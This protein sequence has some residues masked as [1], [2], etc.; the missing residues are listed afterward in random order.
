MCGKN[1]GDVRIATRIPRPGNQSPILFYAIPAKREY[2]PM[3]GLYCKTVSYIGCGTDGANKLT[4]DTSLEL[5]Y[6]PDDGRYTGGGSVYLEMVIVVSTLGCA[7]TEILLTLYP[8]QEGPRGSQEGGHK[9]S[10]RCVRVRGMIEPSR[11]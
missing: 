5:V 7:D 9:D 2:A 6:P 11:R 8:A 4:S 3:E 1:Q 10:K